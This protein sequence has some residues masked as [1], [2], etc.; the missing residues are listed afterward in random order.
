MVLISREP[1]GNTAKRTEFYVGLNHKKGFR[2]YIN[3]PLE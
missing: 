1:F 2:D 3:N